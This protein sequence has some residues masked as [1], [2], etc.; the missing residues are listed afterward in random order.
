MIYWVLYFLNGLANLFFELFDPFHSFFLIS[1]FLLMPLLFLVWLK[2]GGLKLNFGKIISFSL[3][4]S[5]I[6]DIILT[7]SENGILYFA[8]GLGAFLLAHIFY[9]IAFSRVKSGKKKFSLFELRPWLVWP[10]VF[11]FV[12]LISLYWKNLGMLKI[13]V[14]IYAICIIT[15]LA[16][17]INRYSFV[18]NLSWFFVF[19]G[20]LLFV[21]SDSLIGYHKFVV[22]VNLS[23]FWIMLTYILG[24][25]FIV[26]GLL[27]GR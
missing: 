23:R 20:A 22:P 3:L 24:Q 21:I 27:K 8:S 10:L 12:G 15:M 17:S 9:I 5:W 25:G 11:L 19:L 2:N 7:F 13:P 1:R 16:Y 14:L 6:G 18:N 4:F 26:F